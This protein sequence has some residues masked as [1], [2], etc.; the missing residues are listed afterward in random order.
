MRKGKRVIPREGLLRRDGGNR[1]RA[2]GFLILLPLT[3]G[4]R[5]LSRGVLSRPSQVSAS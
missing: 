5:A 4:G 3:P 2:A 1:G